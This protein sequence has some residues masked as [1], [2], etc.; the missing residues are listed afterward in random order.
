MLQVW[1]DQTYSHWSQVPTVQE[2][3]VQANIQYATQ[4]IDDWSE[5][6]LPDQEQIDLQGSQYEALVY[7]SGEI[8][9]PF[10]VT[11]TIAAFLLPASVVVVRIRIKSY[12]IY[13]ILFPLALQ[14]TPKHIAQKCSSQNAKSPC[15]R[16]IGWST[17]PKTCGLSCH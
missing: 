12:N 6:E 11:T 8:W 9:L 3:W 5:S 15:Q 1:Q 7:G 13:L 10:L 2:T 16:G 4:V 17:A 14:I